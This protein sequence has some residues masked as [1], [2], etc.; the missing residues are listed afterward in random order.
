MDDALKQRLIGAILVVGTA[1]IVLAS[2]LG[3]HERNKTVPRTPA[4]QTRLPHNT[5]PVN[6]TPKLKAQDTSPQPMTQLQGQQP[7]KPSSPSSPAAQ[8]AAHKPEKP[9]HSQA[10]G[11]SK[12]AQ[13]QTAR[14]ASQTQPSS[15]AAAQQGQRQARAQPTKPAPTKTAQ[16]PSGAAGSTHQNHSGW[17]VQV[18]SFK[19]RKQAEAMAKHLSKQGFQAFVAHGTVSGHAVYRVRVGPVASPA[20]RDKLAQ[21]LRSRLG[22]DVLPLRQ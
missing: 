10:T 11:Q 7:D 16:A 2:L 15:P 14:Q 22:H 1:V 4:R 5:A 17:V 20:A 12:P 21:R 8:P 19:N 13:G 6:S 9:V 18:A 3:G